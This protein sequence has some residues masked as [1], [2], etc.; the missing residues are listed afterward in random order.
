MYTA[1]L[2]RESGSVRSD[3]GLTLDLTTD[4]ELAAKKYGNDSRGI[5]RVFPQLRAH[6]GDLDSSPVSWA[7][8]KS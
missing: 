8:R 5:P 6:R 3:L 1:Q 2:A 7:A 4:K